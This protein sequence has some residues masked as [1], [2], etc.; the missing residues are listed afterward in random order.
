MP[1]PLSGANP[2]RRGG[3][4]GTQTQHRDQAGDLYHG[5]VVGYLWGS[6]LR[7]DTLRRLLRPNRPLLHMRDNCSAAAAKAAEPAGSAAA[8][9]KIVTIDSCWMPEFETYIAW[10]ATQEGWDKA[11]G[12]ELKLHYFESGMAEMEALPASS[13][14]GGFRWRADVGRSPTPR[15]VYDRHGHR[16]VVGEP[17]HGAPG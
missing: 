17:G 9:E 4:L 6:S 10:K 2:R 15:G 1:D 12:I 3:E 5:D 14:G 7:L 8:P 13:G 11:E 16:R